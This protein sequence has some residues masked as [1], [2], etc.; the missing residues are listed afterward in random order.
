MS[1]MQWGSLKSADTSVEH[2]HNQVCAINMVQVTNMHIAAAIY[3]DDVAL[4]A[5]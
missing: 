1:S 5:P 4:L 3:T 2:L